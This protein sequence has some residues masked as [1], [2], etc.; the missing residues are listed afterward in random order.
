MAS[1]SYGDILKRDNVETLVERING[2]G[3]MAV[4]ATEGGPMMRLTGQVKLDGTLD[5]TLT[6]EELRMY[7]EAPGKSKVELGT[8]EQRFVL[9]TKFFK[10]KDFGGVAAKAGGAGTERQEEGIIIH[11]RDAVK[12]SG[13]I[14]IDGIPVLKIKDAAKNE[15]LSSIG[16]EPYIDVNLITER[17]KKIGCSMKGTSAPSLAGGGL[18]G[19]NVVV[20]HLPPLVYKAIVKHLKS[21][22]HGQGEV[23]D[24]K[25]LPDLYIPVPAEDTRAILEGN[26]AMGGPIEY[27]YI[28]PMDVK[29]TKKGNKLKLNGNFYSIE[30]YM[31]KIPQFYFRVRKR[32]LDPDNMVRIEYEQKNKEGFPRIYTSPRTGRNHLRIVIVDKV[33]ATGKLLNL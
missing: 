25:N 24:N 21:Q 33:P 8:K 19:L 6:A 1:L 23:I 11:I 20:P 27:M 12:E 30:D 2:K 4:G 9:L 18:A 10:S 29:S 7:L 5:K 22:G 26:T 3:E 17:G 28:G 13:P 31:N 14:K 15:G 16:Q 32:D